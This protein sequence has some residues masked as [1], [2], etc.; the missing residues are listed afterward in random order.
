MAIRDKTKGLIIGKREP[1]M[2]LRGIPEAEILL[3]NM[4]LGGHAAAA[5]SGFRHGFADLMDA[6]N[7]QRIGA[8]TVAL[9]LAQ[10]A[11]DHALAYANRA[12]SSAARSPNSRACSGCSPTCPRDRPR[13]LIYKAARARRPG[14]P[15]RRR[16]A[17]QDLRLRNGHQGHQ[18]CAAGVWRRRLFAQPPLERLVR[19]A[20]MFTIAGG[21]A[22]ILRTLV[23]ARSSAGNFHR[24]GTGIWR[25]MSAC[26]GRRTSRRGS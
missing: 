2:G 18:R 21:T 19:D 7:S 16:R 11:Y 1:A 13:A 17:G 24:R 8:A 3:E 25:A 10:G 15:I 14:F 12:S 6:Y 23:A 4:E 5:A 26:R 22:Q 20:R 9:G